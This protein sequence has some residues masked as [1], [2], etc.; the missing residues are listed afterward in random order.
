MRGSGGFGYDS[1]F[2]PQGGER[3]LA[4]MTLD[5]KNSIS[6]R[7]RALDKLRNKLGDVY[8]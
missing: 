6:H 3:T 4:E 2:L 7:K 1:V 5:E 8:A